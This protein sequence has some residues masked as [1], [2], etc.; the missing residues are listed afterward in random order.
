[1]QLSPLNHKDPLTAAS[2]IAWLLRRLKRGEA[3]EGW[4]IFAMMVGVFA[5]LLLNT[6]MQVRL[7][8]WKGLFYNALQDR[9]FQSF[10]YQLGLF[11]VIVLSLLG[12]G[13]AQTWV[14]ETMKVRSRR[15]LSKTLIDAWL[16]PRRAYLLRFA[17]EIAH[18]PDQRITE[19]VRRLADQSIGLMVGLGQSTFLLISFVGVLWQLS[20]EVP[21]TIDGRSVTIPGYMVWCAFAFTFIGSGLTYVFGR[22]LIALNAELYSREGEFRTTLVNISE[23]SE[24]ISLDRGECDERKMAARRLSGVIKLDQ[25]LAT[26]RA[27]LTWVTA[28]YGWVGLIAPIVVAAPG[29]FSNTMTLG[30]LMMVVGAFMQVQNALRWFIDHYP[31][32]AEWQAVLLRV[33]S[34]LK[35]LDGLEP[36]SDAANTIAVASNGDGKLVLDDLAISPPGGNTAAVTVNHQRCEISSGERVLFV[37]PP[38]SGKTALFMALAGLWPWGRGTISLPSPFKAMY[39]AERPHIPLGTLSHAIA[40][41]EAET[42]FSPASIRDAMRYA[43]IAHLVPQCD[44]ADHH[45][46]R[47]LSMGDQQR[48]AMARLLLHK[49]EWVV[50]D[51]S[52]SA[53]PEDAQREILDTIAENLP[54]AS[55]ISTSRRRYGGAFFGRVIELGGTQVFPGYTP[56][57]LAAAE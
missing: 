31:S 15:W 43:G 22:P 42:G 37:G 36:E 24:G 56:A 17:G 16:M 21:F 45:W 44:E 4:V 5:I 35:S 38:G 33:T 18:N 54:R 27:R 52:L 50:L 48:F 6:V 39:L 46:G 53:L 57:V 7:N 10:V 47:D 49:P 30:D 19:D 14:T 2:C 29:Y 32:I 11:F 20:A 12:L 26:M 8:E 1:M 25:A 51:N 3:R 9:N 40:Y 28:G 23:H 13:V 41:P 34:L 55:I